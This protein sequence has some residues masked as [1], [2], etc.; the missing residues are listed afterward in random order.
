[1]ADWYSTG[2]EAEQKVEQELARQQAAR[3]E[4]EKNNIWRMWLPGG[5]ETEVTFLDPEN[6]H[7]DGYPLPFVF[8]EH[9]LKINGNWRNWFTCIGEGCPLCEAGDRPYLGAAYTVINHKEWT[10]KKGG[11]HKDEINLL[12]VK[13]AINVIL[14]KAAARRNG[15]RGW[16]VAVARTSEKAFATGD[17]FDFIERREVPDDL[18]P[19]PYMSLFA[20][21]PPEE[22]QKIYG[23][24]TGPIVDAADDAIK[25]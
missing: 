20:P 11:V 5:S 22:L 23:G 13:P 19:A 1:M 21:K 9:Q 10:D 16:F 7:P 17:S 12:V 4:R 18:Q 15:L 6:K 24:G 25:F 8:T 14:R 2:K 3:E